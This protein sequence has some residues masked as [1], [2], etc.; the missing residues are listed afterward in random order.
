MIFVS[1]IVSLAWV[2]FRH[3]AARSRFHSEEPSR[4]PRWLRGLIYRRQPYEYVGVHNTS[5]AEP[6]PFQR[7]DGRW[8]YHSKQRKLLK[9]EVDDAF[10]IRTTVLVV[11]GLVLAGVGWMAWRLG[12]WAVRAVM[13]RLGA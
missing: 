11:L 4:T 2:D 1:F 7:E 6:Q 5:A 13:I 3:A 9:M 12:G 8:H 10:R